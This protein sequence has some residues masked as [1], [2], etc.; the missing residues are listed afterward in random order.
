M[1]STHRTRWSMVPL[2]FP[3]DVEFQ[4][5][6][7][8]RECTASLFYYSHVKNAEICTVLVGSLLG[9]RWEVVGRIFLNCDWRRSNAS[10][11]QR[12]RWTTYQNLCLWFDSWERFLMDCGFGE[13]CD[14]NF[15]IFDHKKKNILN[16]DEMC[17]SLNGSNGVCGGHPSMTYYNTQFP[18]LGQATSETALAT[19]MIMGVMQ[20]GRQF[21]PIF[22][23]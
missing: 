3:N 6:V 1:S 21:P 18:Q 10:E 23:S 17:S 2:H 15:I 5:V 4:Y 19:T 12:V 13:Y 14:G 8:L 7:Y 9:V 11:E 22:R 20:R 16:L